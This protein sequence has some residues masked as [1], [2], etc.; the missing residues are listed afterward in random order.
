MEGSGNEQA[1]CNLNGVY[2]KKLSKN[3]YTVANVRTS[4]NLNSLI[5]NQ[6]RV[7]L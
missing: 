4:E 5:I 7:V 1:R 3:R 2:A 6:H